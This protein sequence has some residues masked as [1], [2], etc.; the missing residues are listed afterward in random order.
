MLSHRFWSRILLHLNIRITLSPHLFLLHWCSAA[1]C[2][3]LPWWVHLLPLT[4]SPLQLVQNTLGEQNTP[5]SQQLPATMTY[6]IKQHQFGLANTLQYLPTTAP[7]DIKD[8]L[9]SA[10][11]PANLYRKVGF[12]TYWLVQRSDNAEHSGNVEQ[13]TH[14]YV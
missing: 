9:A 12:L 4:A 3:L 13:Q 2:T 10:P 14:Q 8:E 11:T 1:A 5:V 6:S 7:L